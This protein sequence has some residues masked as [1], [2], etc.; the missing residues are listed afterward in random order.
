MPR[1][2][3]TADW[4]LGETR[5]QLMQ[6]PFATSEE[7]VAHLLE[8]HNQIVQPEDLVY[9][10]GDVLWQKADPAIYLPVIAKFNGR[11]I[12]IRG[13]HDRPFTDEQFRPYFEEIYPDGSGIDVELG[14]LACYLT[15]YPTQGRVDHAGAAA[16]W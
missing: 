1:T 3:L 16:H 7:H 12:L 8:K 4:H 13:N 9:V 11:K 10:V 2:F 14:G 5:L 15:H 6:R